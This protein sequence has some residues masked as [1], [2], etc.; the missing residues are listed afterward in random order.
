MNDMIG[1]NIEQI[2]YGKV[3]VTSFKEIDIKKMRGECHESKMSNMWCTI[4][5]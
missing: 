4:R 2:I 3:C 5:E 1:E